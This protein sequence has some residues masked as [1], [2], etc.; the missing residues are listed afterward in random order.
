MVEPLTLPEEF[1]LLSLAETGKVIDS[2]QAEVGCA[3]VELGELALRGKLVIR[4]RQSTVFGLD[5]YHP[6]RA[7][8]E[9]VD[10]GSTSLAWADELLAELA[11]AGEAG[12]ALPSGVPAPVAAS[13]QRRARRIGAQAVARLKR[14]IARGH[15][16]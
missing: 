2:G 14:V 5:V 11:H 4:T 1:A 16:R 8:I 7:E 6:Y 13:H 10:T 9:L 3:V 12:G 15:G